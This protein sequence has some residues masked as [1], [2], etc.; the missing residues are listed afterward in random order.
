MTRQ[1]SDTVLVTFCTRLYRRTVPGISVQLLA[2]ELTLAAPT[3][4]VQSDT[5]V[6]PDI[7]IVGIVIAACILFVMVAAG[8]FAMLRFRNIRVQR[9]ENGHSILHVDLREDIDSMSIGDSTDE[10][11]DTDDDSGTGVSSL[12]FPSDLTSSLGVPHQAMLS[13]R[14][15]PLDFLES[16]NED[17][18][19]TSDTPTRT[20]TQLRIY[21]F[22]VARIEHIKHH[23][24]DESRQDEG[25][26]KQEA[27]EKFVNT[28][29]S[30]LS[31]DEDDVVLATKNRIEGEVLSSPA[32]AYPIMPGMPRPGS[33]LMAGTY[34]GKS[35]NTI[36]QQ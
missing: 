5:H 12:R 8:I 28:K 32:P 15:H 14:A 25:V 6:F 27:M 20:R 11:V 1:S 21:P 17:I 16:D 35:W 26:R 33:G 36:A 24:Q 34:P 18:E 22:V 23:L 2:L 31:T 9:M 3:T 4:A 7:D 19:K 10:E 30:I 13:T 29:T